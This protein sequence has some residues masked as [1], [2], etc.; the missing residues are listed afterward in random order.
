MEWA[1]SG[2]SYKSIDSGKTIYCRTL[3]NIDKF[4]AFHKCYLSY[5]NQRKD[6]Q[7]NKYRMRDKWMIN[8][9]N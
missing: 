1:E 5:K 3:V 8:S 6:Y 2:K 4:Y 9:C 7:F